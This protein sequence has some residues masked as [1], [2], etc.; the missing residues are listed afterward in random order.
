MSF[1]PEG[2][3]TTRLR[4]MFADDDEIWWPGR[5]AKPYVDPA[6]VRAADKIPMGDRRRVRRETNDD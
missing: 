3:I 1:R 4:S 5:D 2:P 6:K